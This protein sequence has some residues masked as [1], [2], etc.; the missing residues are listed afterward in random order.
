VAVYLPSM[1]NDFIYDDIVLIV[2]QDPPRSAADLARIFTERHWGNLPYYRPIARLTMVLQKWAHGNEPA[3]YHLFNAALM[4]MAAVLFYT[5][6]RSA[7]FTAPPPLAAL[8]AALFALHPV[9]ATTVYPI[10]SGRETLLPAVFV[11]AA[12]NAYLRFGRVWYAAALGCFAL[13]LLSKEQAVVTP[14]LF[15]AADALGLSRRTRQRRCAG[16]PAGAEQPERG[17]L[18]RVWRYAP[19]AVVLALY[20]LVRGL[21]F[22]G[23]LEHRI[24]ILEHP[25]LPALSVLYA[26]QT[27]I[28]P[29]A[30]ER[31]EPRLELWLSPPRLL[32]SLV[33]VLVWAA[34]ARRH[35]P[36][37]R[38]AAW[39]W[40]A[41]V[42]LALLPTANL[43][44]QEARFAERY[45][46]LALAG[47][48]GAAVAVLAPAWEGAGQPR[49]RRLTAAVGAALVALAGAVSVH[50]GRYY[51]NDL[52]FTRQWLRA[53]PDSAQAHLYL[54]QLLLAQGNLEEAGAHMEAAL[55]S[56]PAYAEAEYHLAVLWQQRGE[57]VRAVEHLERA[58]R[59]RPAYVEAL[60]NLGLLLLE[61]G[62]LP[63]A[64]ARLER[65]LAL[66]PDFAVAHFNLATVRRREGKTAEALRYLE[67]AVRLEPSHT[68]AQYLLAVLLDASGDGAGA[69]RH[70]ER[71]IRD[72][73]DFVDAHNRL[74]AILQR[75]GKPEEAAAHYRYALRVAPDSIDAHTN[76]G[77]ILHQQGELADAA[78]HLERALALAPEHPEIHNNLGAVLL[79]QGRANEAA[80]QFAEAVR[81]EPGYAEAWNGLGAAAATR[82]DLAA[83]E[84]HFER[85]LRIRPDYATARQSLERVRA[86]RAR[87]AGR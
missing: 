25:A 74:A 57:T 40:V 73:P 24:A 46:L 67:A 60:N 58:L 87:Q 29:F 80:A 69:I 17:I 64:A 4:A 13:A 70:L 35:W 65:A 5:L 52:T 61:L 50:R 33:V 34:A 36:A 23:G 6:L 28:A 32:L 59:I 66:K 21:L 51:R 53:D 76:L 20:F 31:Y 30:T 41:W 54:G 37:A 78:G 86:L 68:E 27:I 10:C 38:R 1:R 62:D 15:V 82:G 84:A 72:R 14:G 56:F 55:V 75:D 83:A 49:T 9:A 85:A 3:G 48:V 43:L 12:V 47:M 22:G 71:A 79:A 63:A 81:L 7:A 19:F 77:V 16:A 18:A 11:L 8:A 26:V 39:F 2:N 44:E 45:G 42:L